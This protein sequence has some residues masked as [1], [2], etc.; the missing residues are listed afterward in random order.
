MRSTSVEKNRPLS[1]TWVRCWTQPFQ[2][3]TIIE[4]SLVNSGMLD[5][6][7]EGGDLG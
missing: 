4:V 1:E 3:N 7:Q 6:L 5:L 2:A